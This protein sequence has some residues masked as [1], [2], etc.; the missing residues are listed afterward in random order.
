MPQRRG[1]RALKPPISGAEMVAHDTEDGVAAMPCLPEALQ[2]ARFYEP[3]ARGFEQRIAE[4]MRD[5]DALRR[6]RDG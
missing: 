2:R 6:G 4:R 3:G 1:S 5:N